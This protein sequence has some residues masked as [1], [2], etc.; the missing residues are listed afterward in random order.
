[1]ANIESLVPSSLRLESTPS[2]LFPT[3]TLPP[4][5]LIPSDNR[6]RHCQTLLLV[7]NMRI[8]SKEN[9]DPRFELFILGDD[10]K[11]VEWKDET[12]KLLCSAQA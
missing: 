7:F 2:Q 11:K 10:E 3:K 6:V 9:D 1:M 5:L 12:R 8:T 4:F